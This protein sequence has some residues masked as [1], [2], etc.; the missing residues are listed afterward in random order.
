MMYILSDTKRAEYPSREPID[1]LKGESLINTP[2]K[3]YRE[4]FDYSDD[5]TN[6]TGLPS[7]TRFE[8]YCEDFYKI[9]NA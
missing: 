9:T 4:L 3:F 1:S 5:G 7:I 2:E 8:I 6:V